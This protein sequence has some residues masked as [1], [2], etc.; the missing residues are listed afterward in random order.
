VH[1]ISPAWIALA[2]SLVCLLPFTRVLPPNAFQEKTDFTPLFYMAGI[3]AL[4]SVTAETGLGEIMGDALLRIIDFKPEHNMRNFFL[5]SLLFS[6]ITLGIIGPGA[7]AIMTPLAAKM[8]EATGFSL[9]TVLMTGI[10]GYSNI[11]FPYQVPPIFVGLQL[12]GVSPTKALKLTFCL[13]IVTIV[14]LIPLN[15]VWWV[16]LGLFTNR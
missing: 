8:A 13:A 1:G 12:A 3:L 7:P 16:W 6:V 10:I 5:L 9:N 2:A 14:F 15:Y 11:L 4:G